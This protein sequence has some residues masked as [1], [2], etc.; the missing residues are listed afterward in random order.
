[1]VLG[2]GPIELLLA[3][4]RLARLHALSELRRIQTRWFTNSPGLFITIKLITPTAPWFSNRTRPRTSAALQAVLLIQHRVLT[5]ITRAG[6]F[7]R[8]GRAQI[9]LQT[10]SK[11]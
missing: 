11:S 4:I 6:R 10:R 2:V 7:M 5:S 9:L 1:M 8:R 3:R